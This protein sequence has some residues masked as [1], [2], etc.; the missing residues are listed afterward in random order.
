MKMN[1]Q[2]EKLRERPRD[3]PLTRDEAIRLVTPLDAAT[4]APNGTRLLHGH[5]LMCPACLERRDV[6]EFRPLQYVERFVHELAV[7]LR[8][9][10]CDHIFALRPGG[11]DV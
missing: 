8:C 5:T 7:P 1:Q 9:P 10:N 3:V 6:L 2:P 4:P 11:P